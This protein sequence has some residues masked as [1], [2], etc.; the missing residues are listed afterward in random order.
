MTPHSDLSKLFSDLSVSRQKYRLGQRQVATIVIGALIVIIAIWFNK[1]HAPGPA[2]KPVSAKSDDT[3]AGVTPVVVAPV[4]HASF[5]INLLAIGTVTPLNAVEVYG[6]VDGQITSIDFKEGQMVKAGDL[7][8]KIDPRL[9]EV[10]LTLA[11][12]Q[13]AR[14]QALLDNAQADLARYRTLL[15][16][17]SISRQQVDTQEALVRQYKAVTQ[18]DQGGI[19]NAKL[20]L[21]HTKIIAPISGR[22]GLRQIDSGNMVRASGSKGIVVITQLQ[23]IAVVFTAPED[24]LPQVMKLLGSARIPVNAYDRSQL[25]NLGK[26]FL[27]AADN[28]ID[29]ATGTIKLKA[30]FSNADGALFANQ[31]V[32]V[33][34]PIETLPKAMLVPTSAIQRGSVGTFVYVVK[35]N[36]TVVVTPV[37]IGPSQ[38]EITVINSGV[39]T[40]S[41]VVVDGADRLREGAKIKAIVRDTPIAAASHSARTGAKARSQGLDPLIWSRD[42]SSRPAT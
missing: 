19:D 37:K 41:M 31:F 8:A 27:L 28:K 23:P 26:G 30:E 20:Q 16:Q 2:N 39:A 35:D 38:G 34:M 5:D 22:V 33:K 32:N 36:Q 3:L 14:D 9:F 15:T 18:A 17:D 24:A 11:T 40:G 42:L 21:S 7:L 12:G 25:Q 10:Q 6:R 13:L 1:D 4:R 29:P